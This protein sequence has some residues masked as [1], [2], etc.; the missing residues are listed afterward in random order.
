[1]AD[2]TSPTYMAFQHD[3]HLLHLQTTV[4]SLQP[5]LQLAEDNQKVFKQDFTD[6]DYVVITKDTI[7]HPQGLCRRATET[8]HI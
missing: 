7:F 2:D 1:M 5:A 3:G 6:Q 8:S 4:L